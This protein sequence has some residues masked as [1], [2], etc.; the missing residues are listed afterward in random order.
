LRYLP[1]EPTTYLVNEISRTPVL[2]LTSGK[3]PSLLGGTP[4]SSY[5]VNSILTFSSAILLFAVLSRSDILSDNFFKSSYLSLLSYN[6]ASTNDLS[7]FSTYFFYSL[8][9]VSNSP[10]LIISSYPCFNAK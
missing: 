10:L 7:I 2:P 9:N 6:P 8:V 5:S 1:I 3:A 4:S